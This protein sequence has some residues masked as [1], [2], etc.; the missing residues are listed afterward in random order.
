MLF[1]SR[2]DLHQIAKRVS[3]PSLMQVEEYETVYQ[4]VSVIQGYVG[5]SVS[6]P[7]QQAFSGFDV[8]A[9]ALPP[10]SMTGAPKKR[11]VELL[12]TIEGHTRGIYSG[13]CGYLSVCGAGDWSVIIRSAFRHS[14]EAARSGT[15]DTWWIGAG[16]AIT[17]LS[18]PEAE[19]EEMLT[20]LQSTLPSFGSDVDF[21]T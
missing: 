7:G 15:A 5:D 20:K 3:V 2:H 19:W 6:A 16:G 21:I 14:D 18:D 9:H 13:V 17:T 8:L 1:R 11:S 12:Q 10:G 4:L